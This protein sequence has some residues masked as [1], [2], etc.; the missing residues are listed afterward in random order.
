M[1][2]DAEC[3]GCALEHIPHFRRVFR[4][5][6]AEPFNV[7]EYIGSSPEFSFGFKFL[8]EDDL[9][10]AA[11]FWRKLRNEDLYRVGMCS[12]DQ[13]VD[14]S[15]AS[16]EAVMPHPEVC[17]E[18]MERVQICPSVACSGTARIA[19]SYRAGSWQGLE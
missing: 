11:Q 16:S 9:H 19:Q 2:E 15:I 5:A 18:A 1:V 8:I 3:R 13:I 10:P 4:L 12:S 14:H 7:A 17:L 6:A